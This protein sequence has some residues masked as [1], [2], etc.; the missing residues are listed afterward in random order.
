MHNIEK[1]LIPYFQILRGEQRKVFKV[2]FVIFNIMHERVKEAVL[3]I[4]Y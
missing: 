2:N 4:P 1:W 3:I